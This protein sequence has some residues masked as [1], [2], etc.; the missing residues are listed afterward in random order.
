MKSSRQG[1][2]FRTILKED[3]DSFP[4]LNPVEFSAAKKKQIINLASALE[5]RNNKPWSE[6]DNFVFDLYGL[7][8]EEATV[9]RD[10]VGFSGP[11][12]AVREPA[13]LPATQNDLNAFC[14]YLENMLQPAFNIAGQSVAVGEIPPLTG[15]WNP[16]WRFVT[17]LLKNDSLP[18]IRKFLA[19]LMGQ[20]NRTAASRIILK[21]PNGGLV[22][23]L[24]NQRRWWT[25]SR[26]RL[27]G[28]HIQHKYLDTFP[29]PTRR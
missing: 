17:I 23:G 15:E 21:V 3:I 10:T 20:A 11:Y 25:K 18:D 16:P 5:S 9:V 1:A 12:R 29:L 2:S 24:L 8:D 4:F 13:E 19:R 6:I 7:D 27:C 26:A 28:L 22:F 14:S